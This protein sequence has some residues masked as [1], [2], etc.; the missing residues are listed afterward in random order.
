M[1]TAFDQSYW[2]SRYNQ[3]ET[4]WD[5]GEITTP[6]KEYIDHLTSTSKKVLI[7]GGGNSYEAEYIFKKGFSNTTV[8]DISHQPL[9]NIK[10]R[11]LT[12]PSQN[13]ICDDFFKHKGSYDLILE[14]TFFCALHPD[15]RAAYAKKMSELL[16]PGGKLVGVLFDADFEGGPPF[17]GHKEEYLRYFLPYFKIK[18][19]ETCYNSIP[20]RAGREL[21][22]ILENQ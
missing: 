15:K 17:G 6:L 13:L 14:Q 20:P 2:E 9:E 12:F 3:Q 4:P 5:V 22:I 19:F 10:E 16:V 1:T 18:T 21:F 11:I 7:P 8:V